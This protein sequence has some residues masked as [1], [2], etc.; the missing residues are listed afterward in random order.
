MVAAALTLGGVKVTKEETRSMA[1]KSAS[2]DFVG[3]VAVVLFLGSVTL[4]LSLTQFAPF[5]SPA[6]NV[7]WIIAAVALIALIADVSKKKGGAFIPST[8][9]ADKN[10]LGLFSYTFFINFSVMGCYI[11]LPLYATYVLGQS[12]AAAGLALT[13]MSAA[14]LFLGPVYGRMIGKAGNAR[15][16]ALL[17]A[18]VRIAILVAFILLLKP[19]SSIWMVYALMLALG[20]SSSGGS[21][22][23]AVEPQVQI[24]PEKRQMGNSVVQLGSGFGSSI[25]IAIYTMVIASAGVAGGMTTIFMISAVGAAIMFITSLMLT[26]LPVKEATSEK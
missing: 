2:F 7:L 18:A 21:V 17:T 3:A 6:N 26:K 22:V 10:V 15:G 8:V 24:A 1:A 11:F 5:G 13:C 19:T 14:G 4:G 16:V 12:A 25:S 20:V 23:P 9:L